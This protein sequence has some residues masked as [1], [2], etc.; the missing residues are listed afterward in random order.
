VLVDRGLGFLPMAA[1]GTALVWWLDITTPA[2][3]VA[4]QALT[5]LGVVLGVLMVA[6]LTFR[7]APLVSE[8]GMFERTAIAISTRTIAA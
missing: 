6:A 2:F 1:W 3:M 7:L 5:V 8:I 4:R